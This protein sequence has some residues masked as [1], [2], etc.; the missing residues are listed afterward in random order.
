[1]VA[2]HRS[3]FPKFKNLIDEIL[4]NNIQLGLHSEIWEDKENVAHANTIEEA[5]E[6]HGIQYVSTPRL[7]RRGGGAAITL[8]VD[9][10]FV[11][12]KLDNNTMAGEQS[13]EVCW[14]L[15]KPKSPTGHIKTLIVCA[16]YL[17]PNSRKKS[18]LI[19]HISL[20]YYRLKS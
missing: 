15:L 16:F 19:E 18:A 10:P 3:I 13:L 12:T 8:I 1:M 6:L 2:N 14:G 5:L 4:E 7:N 9:S 20:N 17:P 11:L